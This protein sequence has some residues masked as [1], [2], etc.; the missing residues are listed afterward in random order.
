MCIIK[1]TYKEIKRVLVETFDCPSLIGGQIS[2]VYRNHVKKFA[3]QYRCEKCR[4]I[5]WRFEE[6]S[7]DVLHGENVQAIREAFGKAF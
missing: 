6:E 5:K 2:M 1:H 3:V 4:K 7:Y